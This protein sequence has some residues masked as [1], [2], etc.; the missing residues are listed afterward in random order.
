MRSAISWHNWVFLTLAVVTLGPRPVAVAQNAGQ[1]SA[2]TA[3]SHRLPALDGTRLTVDLVEVTYGPGAGSSP[4]THPCPVI[5]YVLEGSIR[6][7]VT[8][9]PATTYQAGESFYEP[10]NGV[11]FVSANASDKRPA[12]LLAVF[13]C[14]H[15][16]PLSSP[17][18]G[19]R[20]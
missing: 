7:Q 13:I 1:R 11:H 6:S 5:G 18:K 3:F 19:D 10:L 12:R 14:D 8:G 9:Q 20:K 15:N 2:R 4:H 16:A 17:V